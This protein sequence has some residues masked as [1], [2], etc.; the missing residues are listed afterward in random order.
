MYAGHCAGHGG[1]KMVEMGACLQG[2]FSLVGETIPAKRL[3]AVIEV[4][5]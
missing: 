1:G 3:S 5:T 4:C 2:T